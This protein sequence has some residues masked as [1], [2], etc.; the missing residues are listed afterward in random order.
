[1][2]GPTGARFERSTKALSRRVGAEVLVTTPSDDEVHELSG[3]AT[4]V[5]VE[6]RTATRVADLVDHVALA[7]DVDPSVIASQV[8]GCLD[9]LLQLGVVEEVHGFDG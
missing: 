2:R 6:L 9:T 5:W 3:G 7:H 8:E 1:M 4:A